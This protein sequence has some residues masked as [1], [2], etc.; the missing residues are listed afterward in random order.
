M[1]APHNQE[2]DRAIPALSQAQG[3]LTPANSPDK[4]GTLAAVE[5]TD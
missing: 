3:R 1:R 2:K 5:M 4:L